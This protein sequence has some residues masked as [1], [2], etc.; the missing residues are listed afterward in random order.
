MCSGGGAAAAAGF[1]LGSG[2]VSYLVGQPEAHVTLAYYR[3]TW[4]NP[5]IRAEKQSLR[6]A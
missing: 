3:Y 2:T 6:G 4:V 1:K 5:T